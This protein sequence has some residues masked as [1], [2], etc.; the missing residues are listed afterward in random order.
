MS[1]MHANSRR[2]M[3]RATPHEANVAHACV[4]HVHATTIKRDDD[5][6]RLCR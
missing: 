5:A 4:K 1:M 2:L 3:M 6:R